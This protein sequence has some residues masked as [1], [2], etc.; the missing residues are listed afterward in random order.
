VIGT[1]EFRGFIHH[2]VI[3]TRSF[4]VGCLM[5]PTMDGRLADLLLMIAASPAKPEAMLILQTNGL[6]LHRHDYGKM[7]DAGLNQLQVS[8]DTADPGTQRSLRSGMSLQK[9]LRNIAGFRQA[10][11]RINVT[12]VA[13]VTSEN[14]GN[15]ADL[16]ALGLD[17][18]AGQF[19]FREVFYHPESD[20]VD[21]ERMPRLL[22][23]PGDFATMRQKILQRFGAS[24]ASFMFA[25]EHFLQDSTHK[26][27][28][29]S[30]R[31]PRDNL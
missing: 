6:L 25:D 8:L 17:V 18:G 13:T 12:L 9:V 29:D 26:M 14:I 5:E 10:C 28:S 16:V 21:H 11:P 15:I 20:V 7:N 27:L 23:K 24:G 19:V 1:E 31:L 4:Q 22:L 3:S 2:N 30:A